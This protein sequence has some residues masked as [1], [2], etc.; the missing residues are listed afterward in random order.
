MHCV[1]DTLFMR[2]NA[3]VSMGVSRIG[4]ACSSLNFVRC[5]FEL[6][7]NADCSCHCL[8]QTSCKYIACLQ[9]GTLSGN[10]LAMT[11]GLK[12]LEI[13]DRPGAYEHLEKVTGRLIEGILQ[14]GRDAGH[15]VSGGHISGQL[16]HMNHVSA[17]TGSCCIC[18]VL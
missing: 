9:A 10:P 15:A 16:L 3:Q 1:V 6:I 8:R 4:V 14:A 13:L 18:C 2:V 12:T 7:E 5:R 17:Q 11:A